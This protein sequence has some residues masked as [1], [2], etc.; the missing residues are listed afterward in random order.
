[1]Q[2][3]STETDKVPGS[4]SLNSGPRDSLRPSEA[5]AEQPE[6]PLRQNS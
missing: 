6:D 3:D 5:E 4:E 2:F 1:M